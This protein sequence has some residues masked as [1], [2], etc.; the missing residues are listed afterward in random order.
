M[1]DEKRAA[2]PIDPD[3]V[4]A[5]RGSTLI[6]VMRALDNEIPCRFIG[7]VDTVSR[8]LSSAEPLMPSSDR[9]DDNTPTPEV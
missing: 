8:A 4:Y 7:T 3:M 6:A 2:R 5:L 1:S 9:K